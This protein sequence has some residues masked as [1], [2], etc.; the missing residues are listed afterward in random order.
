[1]IHSYA[2]IYALGHR[3]VKPLLD[4]PVIVQEK[5]D[6]SQISFGMF[7]D[8]EG[9]WFPAARSKGAPLQILAPDKMFAKGVDTV[10]QLADSLI[11]NWTYRG[12]YLAK[13]KHNALAYDR[14]PDR[15][16]ILFDVDMGDQDYLRPDQLAAEGRRIGLE[17]VPTLYDGIVNDAGMFRSLLSTTSILGGQK[18]EG[19]VVKNYALYGPDKKVLMGKFV[20]EAFKEVHAHEWTKDNP[21]SG[22]ILER[23]AS[24]YTTAAR[25][26]KALQHLRESGQIED[27]PRDI[28]LLI[29]EVWPDIEK[30]CADAIKDDLY[31]WAAGSLRRMSTRGL[32]EWYKQRLLERQFADV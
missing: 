24:K 1:M 9:E 21:K 15:H 31:E 10:L 20:S 6:G 2:S 13:P 8:I 30:E 23:L 29:R 16:I 12:E 27:S 32:P 3:A 7:Q 22:D 19:V 14:V 18:V 11:P 25:W 5:I 17:T 4:S 28:G 26:E